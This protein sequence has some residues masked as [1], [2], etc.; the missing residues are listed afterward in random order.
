LGLFINR[1]TA[2][3]KLATAGLFALL[4][5]WMLASLL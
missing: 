4:T 3:V 2:V 1:H 5:V